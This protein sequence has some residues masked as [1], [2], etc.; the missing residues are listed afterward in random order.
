MK[1]PILRLRDTLL[2][3]I[4]GDLTDQDAIEFQADILHTV[5]KTG[6]KG[7]VIDITAMSVVDSFLARILSD[8]ASM[9][10]LLGAEAVIC[11]MQPSV[12][13]A[14]VEMGRELLNVETALNLEQGIERLQR[15]METK[16][17]GDEGD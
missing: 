14:L 11:G 8:T 7:V 5:S 10:R 16:E 15:R 17:S 13:L 3:S 12:A 4:Q 6:A 9:V 1:V 2:A